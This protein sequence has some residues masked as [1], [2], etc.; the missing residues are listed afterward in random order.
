MFGLL[1][2]GEYTMR[3]FTRKHILAA[4]AEGLAFCLKC[5]EEQGYGED[6]EGILPCENCG[7][8]A[9]IPASHIQ[10]ILNLVK[11]DEDE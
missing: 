8:L 1:F 6:V 9:V 2:N 10:A 4:A 5:G 3:Q 11:G 7:A